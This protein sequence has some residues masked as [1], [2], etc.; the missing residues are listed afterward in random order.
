MTNLKI[1]LIK[2]LNSFFIAINLAL[3]LLALWFFQVSDVDLKIQNHFY[4][5]TTQT[6]LIDRNEPVKKL[7]FYQLPKI[8]LGGL[9]V[10][11]LITCLIG[12]LK[13]KNKFYNYRHQLLLTLIGLSLIPL[14]A[15]NVKKFTNIYCPD[16]LEIYNGNKP[17]VKIFDH[18]PQGFVQEKKGQCFP[19]GH[20][21]TGFSLYILAFV[22]L[23][24][25]LKYLSFFT[26][27][28][29]GW[30]LGFYQILKGAHF[31]SD[32]LIAMLLSLLIAQIIKIIFLSK[33]HS[34]FSQRL[35]TKLT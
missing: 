17:Y 20:A 23:N 10:I 16:Q 21:V 31:I 27:T 4:N 32:T 3:I 25:K 26:A 9:I 24:K 8:L 11:V 22:F 15:G 13:K 35:N 1:L 29:V 18:Y 28:I 19:A 34:D 5:F 7:L 14:I 30:V 33:L 2:N 6:W 12:F